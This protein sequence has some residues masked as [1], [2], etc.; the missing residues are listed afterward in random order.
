MTRKVSHPRKRNPKGN[1][2]ME[3]EGGA[4]SPF[5]R[6]YDTNGWIG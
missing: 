4:R 6:P 2:F 1:Y 3:G 5:A